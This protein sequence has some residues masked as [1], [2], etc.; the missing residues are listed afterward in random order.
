MYR[1]PTNLQYTLGIPGTSYTHT[2]TYTFNTQAQQDGISHFCKMFA[3]CNVSACEQAT[4][5]GTLLAPVAGRTIALTACHHGVR[6]GVL[7]AAHGRAATA[8]HTPRRALARATRRAAVT[9]RWNA[10]KKVT[11]NKRRSAECKSQEHD[12]RLTS[13]RAETTLGLREPHTALYRHCNG[14]NF[15]PGTM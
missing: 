13:K 4:Q 14:C 10:H 1:R 3:N 6:G 5:T 8:K 11:Q 15:S 2:R 7:R 12:A 9:C